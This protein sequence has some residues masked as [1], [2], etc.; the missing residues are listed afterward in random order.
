[1]YIDYSYLLVLWWL[2]SIKRGVDCVNIGEVEELVRQWSPLIWL[3]PGE[4][5]L[6][7]SAEDYLKHVKLAFK[8]GSEIEKVSLDGALQDKLKDAILIP[9][10]SINYLMDNTSSFIYGKNPNL[11]PVITYALVQQCQN[12]TQSDVSNSD[13]SLHFHVSYWVFFPYNE[14]KQVCFIGSIPTLKIFNICLGSME[15]LGNHLGDWEH[16][17]L[18]FSGNRFPDQLYLAF[19]DSG[20]YYN[21]NHTGRY[22]RFSHQRKS[23]IQVPKFP[24]IVRTQGQHPVV[25]SANGSHGLWS[26]PGNI[27]FVRIPRLT[28]RNGYGTYWKTWNHIKIYHLNTSPLPFWLT[29]RG[30]WGNPKRNC[31]LFK[32]LGICQYSEGPVGPLWHERDFSCSTRS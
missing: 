32:K 10:D 12:N 26:A 27:D 31:Y 7:M 29:Y 17:S 2:L 19:H 3:A 1:M 20:V 21:Y 22:F 9:N 14:G 13:S 11:Q 23:I 5:Y 8:N 18:T 25:F 4:K 15:T 24:Q 16:M 28:D 30:K 6:P